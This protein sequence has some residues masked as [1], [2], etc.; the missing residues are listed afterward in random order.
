VSPRDH[1][2]DVLIAERAPTLAAGPAWPLLRPLLYGLLDYGK[3]R[4]MADGIAPLAGAQALDFVSRLLDVRVDV[5]GLE[6]VP[7]QGRVIAICNHPTGIADGVAVRDALQAARPDLVFYANADAARVAPGFD[8]VLIPVEWVESK[9]TL[10]RTRITLSRTRQAM[11][12]EQALVIFPSGRLSRRRAGVLADPPWAGGAFSVARRYAAPIVPMHLSGPWSGLF[13]LFD[14]FSGELRDITLF[15]ELLNKRGKRFVLVVGHPVQASC[16]PADPT[17]A[18]LA[19]KTF[20]EKTLAR[21]V[22]ARFSGV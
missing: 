3:A 9:R 11:E 13:H 14:R 5:A 16:L 10:S 2:I 20:V 19:M 21:D 8:D 4:R 18:A 12:N 7:R 15:H 22:G 6:R 17:E 1:I